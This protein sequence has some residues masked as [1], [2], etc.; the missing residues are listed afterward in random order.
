MHYMV[1]KEENLQAAL[2]KCIYELTLLVVDIQLIELD[3]T[4]THSSIIELEKHYL[5]AAQH[6]PEIMLFMSRNKNCFQK[7][8]ATLQKV[9]ALN[10][11]FLMERIRLFENTEYAYADTNNLICL[12]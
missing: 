4:D 8:E 7:Q 6:L 11:D 10:N 9:L 12:N 5:T 1:I 3:T 2:L